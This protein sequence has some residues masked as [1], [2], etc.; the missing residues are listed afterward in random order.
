MENNSLISKRNLYIASIILVIGIVATIIYVVS[1]IDYVKVDATITD[2]EIVKNYKNRVVACYIT[3]NYEYENQ[4]YNTRIKS[5][6]RLSEQDEGKEKIIKIDPNNPEKIFEKT[7]IVVMLV[8]D[9]TALMFV[10]VISK[11]L[12][13]ENN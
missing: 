4:E 13:K 12:K 6:K 9:V 7:F 5:S 1:T 3:Y 10:V 11:D 2:V 8:L